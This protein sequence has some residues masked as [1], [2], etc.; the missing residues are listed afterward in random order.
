MPII[1][2]LSEPKYLLWIGVCYTFIITLLFF[3]PASDIPKLEILLFD[4]I[5]HVVIHGLLSG[6]WLWYG[7]RYD[8]NHFS[9]KTVFVVLSICFCYGLFI[10][11]FQHWFTLTRTFDVFDVVANAI[12]S[13]LGLFVFWKFH[14][15]S[16]NIFKR[17]TNGNKEER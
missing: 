8:Q 12:G 13:L 17:A 7:F 14:S 9:S 5:V 4:K 11:A 2:K 16:S 15:M 10:E 1:K 3:T 6:I